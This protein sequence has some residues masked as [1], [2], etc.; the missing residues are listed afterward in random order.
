[1]SPGSVS[2]E[3]RMVDSLDLDSLLQIRQRRSSHDPV[4]AGQI[5][6]AVHITKLLSVRS[7]LS[8]SRLFEA[9]PFAFPSCLHI[10]TSLEH[11]KQ[12]NKFANSDI[13]N[14]MQVDRSRK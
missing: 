8:P 9:A 12:Y 10:A 3:Q 1:M 14:S 13:R 11:P 6:L 2:V 4:Q 7:G 5:M